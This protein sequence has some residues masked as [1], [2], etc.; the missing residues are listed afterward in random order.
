MSDAFTVKWVAFN[1]KVNRIRGHL[2]M[3]DGREYTFWSEKGKA[4]DFKR[5]YNSYKISYIKNESI[6][7]GYKPLSTEEYEELY[8]NFIEDLEIFLTKYILTEE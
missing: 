3:T 1:K 8:P 7:K 6:R 5:H 2:T 4:I